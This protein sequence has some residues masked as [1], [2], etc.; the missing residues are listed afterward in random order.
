MG[1]VDIHHV[2]YKEII[3]LLSYQIFSNKIN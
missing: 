1:N 3:N 2:H